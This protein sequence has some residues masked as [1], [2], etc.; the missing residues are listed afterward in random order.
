MTQPLSA[1]I[2]DMA[3]SLLREPEAVPSSEAAHAALL[4]AHIAWNRRVDVATPEP[5]YGPMLREFEASNPDLWNELKSTN[6]EELIGELVAHREA[7]YR[8]DRRFLVVCGMRDD[9]VHAEWIDRSSM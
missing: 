8:D 1:I 4:L 9:K 3:F 2:K 6:P 5:A 7:H